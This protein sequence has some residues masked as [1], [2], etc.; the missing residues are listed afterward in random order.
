M[1]SNKMKR[2]LST[3]LAAGMAFSL[4]AC[5]QG[6][7]ANNANE[8]DIKTEQTADNQSETAPEGGLFKPGT[9]TG[10]GKGNNGDVS[11][12]VTF[13]ANAITAVNVSEHAE[14]AGIAD[15][16]LAD[17]PAAILAAQSTQ[18][19]TISGATNTSNA[20]IEAVNDAIKQAGADPANLAA[21]EADQEVS[22]KGEQIIE[23]DVAVVGGGLSGLSAAVAAAQ[24]G[25][26]VTLIE[27]MGM[28]GGSSALSGGGIGGTN[29]KPQQDAGITDTKEDW[30][31]L[32]EERQATSPG[33]TD[34]PQ[35]EKV[36][37][38]IE[39]SPETID[40]FLDL[41]YSFRE[42]EGFGVDPV[43]RLHF[44]NPEGNGAVLIDYLANKAKELGVE[45]ILETPATELIQTDG[46]VTGVKAQGKDG[47][48][49]IN[50][51]SVI[52]ASGGFGRSKELTERFAPAVVDYVDYSVSGAG[53]T[54]DGIVMAESVGA[55]PYEDPWFIGLG[56]K[57]P[58][59]EMNAFY[60]N[61]NYTF[62]NNEGKRFT[63]EAG[64]YAIV[65]NDAVYNAPGGAYMVFDSS[66]AFE[67]YKTAADPLVDN[68]NVF[69]GETLQELAEAAGINAENLAATF[70]S[71]NK[72]KD[73]EFGKA[74]E[75][76][77]P[78]EKGPFYAAKFY[79]SNM[80]TFGGVKVS[81]VGEV[82]DS[83]NNPIAGLYA[84]GEMANRPYYNQV[85]M[86]GSALLVATTTGQIAGNA[87]GN[88]K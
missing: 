71:Y 20:I 45:I 10:T 15:G 76:C 37:A 9:Y 73:K 5:S 46:A 49:T 81:D 24:T 39:R 16:A 51:K 58:V 27:K 19:D 77:L 63:N 40:W 7:N 28:L 54:G 84:V 65:F 11:V 52:L 1:I 62:I 36:D 85:Y 60:W 34:F 66:D 53:N 33:K 29:T 82:L 14:T 55:V 80:G 35:W 44:P 25:A 68:V 22:A 67:A 32:W 23:A 43:Q 48:V 12:E 21:P 75:L 74:D 6:N 47:D 86:S 41:G 38:L 64:H 50:A 87:A 59:N 70:E 79:P 31:K 3:L 57:S 72:D 61:G 30:K 42:P 2:I 83:S 26:K 18:I 8:S 88:A 4:F 13:D 78:I 56:L 69:K 17:I